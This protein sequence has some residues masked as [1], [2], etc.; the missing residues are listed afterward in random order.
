MGLSVTFSTI[1]INCHFEICNKLHSLFI[2]N[3]HSSL[4]S[5]THV[6]WLRIIISWSAQCNKLFY[7]TWSVTRKTVS[8]TL[9]A[10]AESVDIYLSTFQSYVPKITVMFT[11]L[12]SSRQAE[13]SEIF[14][15]A[16]CMAALWLEINKPHNIIT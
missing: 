10:I 13:M 2:G 1:I 11:R 7:L 12:A 9:L 4:Q 15:P 5:M 16:I 3:N 14:G 8:V 6:C